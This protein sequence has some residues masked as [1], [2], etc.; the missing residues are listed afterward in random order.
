MGVSLWTWTIDWSAQLPISISAYLNGRTG[1]LFPLFPWA[2]YALL[3]AAAGS[4][5][6]RY[7]A[8]GTKIPRYALYVTGAVLL[9]AGVA[10]QSSL[11]KP[12]APIESSPASPNIGLIRL[13]CVVLVLAVVG[14]LVR[15]LRFPVRTLHSLAQESLTVY[16]L[17]V[18]ILYGSIWNPGIRQWIGAT[19]APLSAAGC[20]LILVFSMILLAIA[21]NKAKQAKPIL[22]RSLCVSAIVALPMLYSL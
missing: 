13:G 11:M 21:W 3:G 7:R 5:W 4:V 15:C 20:A 6:G 14:D 17:H 1:S 2:G 12:Y 9:L 8:R 16:F 18:C 22:C 10:L 19:M